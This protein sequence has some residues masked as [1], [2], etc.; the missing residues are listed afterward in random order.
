MIKLVM[1]KLFKIL[2]FSAFAI[3]IQC[4]NDSYN[5]TKKQ[6]KESYF[7]AFKT[8]YLK[9]A[10]RISYNN[11]EA[12]NEVLK[13]DH[14]GFSDPYLPNEDYLLID[15]IIRSDYLQIQKDSIESLGGAVGGGAEGK[16]PL[17]FIY[18]KLNDKK[19]NL[20][21]K[22]RFNNYMKHHR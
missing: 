22:Q 5:Y 17:Y 21:I 1:K 15:S 10:L 11:S 16:A 7:Y 19:F 20:F 18:E 9:R 6:E 4:K 12:I 3:F 13:L 14:S 8:T 2:L